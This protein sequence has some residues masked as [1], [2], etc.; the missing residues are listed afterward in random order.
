MPG[1]TSF[2]AS[3]LR[4]TLFVDFCII[5]QNGDFIEEPY[6]AYD[7]TDEQDQQLAYLRGAV[8]E[9]EDCFLTWS[10]VDMSIPG[11]WIVLGMLDYD[12]V[13]LEEETSAGLQVLSPLR[14]SRNPFSGVVEFAGSGSELNIFDVSGRKVTTL[15]S[16]ED[17]FLWNGLSSSGAEAPPGAYF[18][19][20]SGGGERSVLRIV[21]LE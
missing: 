15:S 9:E 13:G 4:G 16:S 17:H 19:V 1:D 10:S 3:W 8:N 6:V 18:V 11:C 7:Y 12:W 2:Y 14:V 5:D 21:K 20:L